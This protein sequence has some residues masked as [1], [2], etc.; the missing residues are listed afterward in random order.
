MARN[1]QGFEFRVWKATVMAKRKGAKNNFAK[2][3]AQNPEPSRRR[4]GQALE[5]NE[6]GVRLKVV[7]VFAYLVL[8]FTVT[9]V[10][11]FYTGL[12]ITK[13]AQQN[14]V[15]GSLQVVSQPEQPVSVLYIFFYV[16]LGALVMFLL[17]RYYKGDLLFILIEF[18]V[19]S[20][21]SSIVFYALLK[22]FLLQTELSMAAAMRWGLPS[23]SSSPR[24]LG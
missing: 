3:E 2:R 10:L 6:Q 4:V 19:V 24:S 11:G 13:D 22:P 8:L 23:G 14:E 17:V 18:A 12:F 1:V 20:F 5:D 21:S 7:R 16:L 9:Q 15:I